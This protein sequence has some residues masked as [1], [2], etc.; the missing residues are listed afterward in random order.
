[1]LAGAARLLAAEGPSALTTRR[2]A[3]EAGTSTMAVYT[4]FGSLLDVHRAV[5]A[6]GFARLE[7][8]LAALPDT[9]DPVSD[10]VAAA[11]AY[12]DFAVAEP[13]LYRT[14]TI[15]R[16]PPKENDTDP[17]PGEQVFTMLTG[18][19]RRC[20]DAGRFRGSPDLATV[21]SAQLWTMQHGMAT[22]ALADTISPGQIRFV[23]QDMAERLCVGYGD[24]PARARRSVAAAVT[25][26]T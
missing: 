21:W 18:H 2:L 15:D 19:V 13:H 6:D 26:E 16:P 17:D 7:A 9:D 1:M 22:L 20:L 3:A 12:L 4:R 10:L 14:M 24:D 11:L 8:L 23:L 5:R 25:P